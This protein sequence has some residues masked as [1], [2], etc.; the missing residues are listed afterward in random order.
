MK[1]LSGVSVSNGIAIGPCVV[2][3]HQHLHI[4]SYKTKDADAERRR[5]QFAKQRV[6]QNLNEQLA[7][8]G[9]TPNAQILAAHKTM[10]NDPVLAS[11]IEQ[12]LTVDGETAAYAVSHN[13]L[14][15]AQMLEALPDE[16]LR[17]RAKDLEDLRMQWILALQGAQSTNSVA[18]G[19][20]IVTNELLPS[21]FLQLKQYDLLGIVTAQGSAT[22]HVCILARSFGV[23]MV[24]NINISSIQ[25]GDTL[26]VDGNL[27]AV[28]VNPDVQ[29]SETL[30]ANHEEFVNLAAEAAQNRHLEARTSTGRIVE[31]AA[32]IGGT[33]DIDAAVEGGADGI[34]L[35]R[36]ELLFMG[37][38]LAPT[39]NEQ[40]AAYQQVVL[41]MSGK[42]VVIRTLD[43][44]VD[45]KLPYLNFNQ[46]DN[47][48]LGLH[49]IRY[50]LQHKNVLFTQLRAL[51][52]AAAFGRISVMFPLITGE[53]DI[54]QAIAAIEE[55]KCQLE[56]EGIQH[57]AIEVGA[58][59]EVPAAAMITDI[60]AKKL[61]FVSVGTNDLIQYATAADR[62]N[63]HVTAWYD[64]NHPGLWRMLDLIVR[65]AHSQGT[66]VGMCGE[67]AGSLEHISRLVELGFDELSMSPNRIGLIK[68]AIRKL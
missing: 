66:W 49:G 30:R 26:A 28:I 61:D 64:P 14:S 42:R 40:F 57:G 35:F 22:S 63:P 45:K 52:R 68:T 43:T 55:A 6:E 2:L 59:I 54:E 12:S 18:R 65:G 39:E 56:G 3:E 5:V 67:L 47:P 19:I 7:S 17:A 60:L 51:L 44:G 32:N 53:Q 23:P 11:N 36:T 4:E 20:I 13:I 15:F 21:Q 58:M 8:L 10:L 16:Y 37:R 27:G 62:M 1:H 50:T 48:S 25:P 29:T 46:E 34:G 9:D 41:R 33:Q 24:T 38:P 31:I